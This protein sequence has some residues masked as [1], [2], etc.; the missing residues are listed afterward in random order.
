MIPFRRQ[1]V[2]L[3][4]LW[5][6]AQVNKNIETITMFV[7][8]DN[9]N[10][11]VDRMARGSNRAHLLIFLLSMWM[12][13]G[14]GIQNTHTTFTVGEF[15]FVFI[16]Q[17]WS[18]LNFSLFLSHTPTPSCSLSFFQ[19]VNNNWPIVFNRK[20]IFKLVVLRYAID[21]D[22]SLRYVRI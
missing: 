7:G 21:A 8:N 20:L 6:C 5:M 4:L 3:T 1:S 12:I 9:T 18:Y 22:M 11:L 15:R 16:E 14:K 17:I 13:L 2:R 10:H 19:S